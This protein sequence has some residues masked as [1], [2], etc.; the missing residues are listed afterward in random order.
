MAEKLVDVNGNEVK[1]VSIPVL[2]YEDYVFSFHKMLDEH[3][4]KF[5][6]GKN[7][8][9][10]EVVTENRS[11]YKELRDLTTIILAALCEARKGP[12]HLD[13][14]LK[15]IKLVI[16]DLNGKQFYPEEK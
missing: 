6:K 9:P 16:R 5:E 13:K 7:T 4:V 14:F 12:E 1:Q 10:S 3:M 8:K 15:N 2:K 11:A